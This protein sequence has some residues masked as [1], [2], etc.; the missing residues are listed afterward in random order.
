MPSELDLLFNRMYQLQRE[1]L[2]LKRIGLTVLV[3]IGA[4]L[5]MGQSR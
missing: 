3:L 1:N 4:G 2:R 5:L